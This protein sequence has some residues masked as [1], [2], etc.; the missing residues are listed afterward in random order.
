[1]PTV[2]SSHETLPGSRKNSGPNRTP[3]LTQSM[4]S[5]ARLVQAH[6]T[7]ELHDTGKA[8]YLEQ[9]CGGG[10]VGGK[11]VNAH[12]A[13]PHSS[14]GLRPITRERVRACGYGVRRAADTPVETPR[15]H[16]FLDPAI[17]AACIDGESSRLLLRFGSTNQTRVRVYLGLLQAHPALFLSN[18]RN[19]ATLTVIRSCFSEL[20][21]HATSFRCTPQVSPTW[22]QASSGTTPG[23]L[24]GNR[25]QQVH[26][27]QAIQD[28]MRHPRQD[29]PLNLPAMAMHTQ[30]RT[31]GGHMPISN[32]AASQDAISSKSHHGFH[33]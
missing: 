9:F 6:D 27:R 4:T 24:R 8:G 25:A 12:T 32:D 26:M 21:T 17:L 3:H 30:P 7:P 23:E 14:R 18:N 33:R 20:L 5:D 13:S 19:A 16:R 29:L 10:G 22:A 28:Q 15:W 31:E 1:M 2:F 11:A